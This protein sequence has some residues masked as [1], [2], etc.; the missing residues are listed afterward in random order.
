MATLTYRGYYQV[1]DIGVSLSSL[2]SHLYPWCCPTFVV[3]L[4]AA[5]LVRR[6]IFSRLLPFAAVFMPRY[7]RSCFYAPLCSLDLCSVVSCLT[8]VPV[9]HG[10]VAL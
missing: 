6:C 4:T 5:I 2:F 8:G 10:V 9:R 7:V 3:L 1:V